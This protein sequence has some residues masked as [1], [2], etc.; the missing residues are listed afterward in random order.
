MVMIKDNRNILACQRKVA[1][2]GRL[3]Y[4]PQQIFHMAS[5]HDDQRQ[6]NEALL[7]KEMEVLSGQA[8]LESET[9][10]QSYPIPPPT[11][12]PQRNNL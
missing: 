7:Y 11:A 6:P 4:Q 1:L 8:E 3:K 12:S 5:W 2:I 10:R 9:N